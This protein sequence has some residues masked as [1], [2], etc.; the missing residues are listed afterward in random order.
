MKQQDILSSKKSDKCKEIT[1]PI[2]PL[3][4]YFKNIMNYYFISYYIVN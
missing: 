2:Q 3:M 1:L 4:Q